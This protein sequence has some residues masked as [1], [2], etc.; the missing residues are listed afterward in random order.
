MKYTLKLFI[1]GE[2]PNSVRAL[3]N[4]KEICETHLPGKYDIKVIDIL[5]EPQLA[6]DEKIVAAPTVVKELPPPIKQ[7]IGTLSDKEKVLLGL[8]LISNE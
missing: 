3:T 2:T 8:D 7:I 1:I 6:E 5:K 4:L